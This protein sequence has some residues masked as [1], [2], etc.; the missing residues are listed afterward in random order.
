MAKPKIKKKQEEHPVSTNPKSAFYYSFVGEF[1]E[2]IC[3][4]PVSQ[5]EIGMFPIVVQGYLLELD[6]NYLYLSDDA[7][8]ICRAVNRKNEITIEIVKQMNEQEEA[9]RNILVPD[10]P[11]DGN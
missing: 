2:I 8:T 3:D 10:V 6:D 5:T 7:L 9:L 1:V 4:G 11:E